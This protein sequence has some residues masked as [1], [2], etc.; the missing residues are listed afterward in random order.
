MEALPQTRG[1]G[2]S[3]DDRFRITVELRH[4]VE[5]YGRPG[6]PKGFLG[7]TLLIFP[8][9]YARLDNIDADGKFIQDEVFKVGKSTHCKTFTRKA[10]ASARGLMATFV[11]LRA[12][13][14]ELFEGLTIM[15]QPAGFVDA[16]LYKWIVEDLAREYPQAVWQ[17]DALQTCFTKDALKWMALAQ[18]LAGLIAGKM[19]P[20]LQLT[21]TDFS[22]PF[23]AAATRAKQRLLLSLKRRSRDAGE[24]EN[25]KRLVHCEDV[26]RRRKGQREMPRRSMKIVQSPVR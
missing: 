14:P 25:L 11:K 8:G 23:K 7:K 18:Q 9:Q 4:L 10:G 20:V 16:V 19:A 17:R 13:R 12:A 6:P 15:Q 21:D 5:G 2:D 22:F 24:K 3:G 26:W 1:Q